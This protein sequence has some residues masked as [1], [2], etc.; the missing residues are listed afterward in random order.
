MAQNESSL[1][2]A[3]LGLLK[4][5]AMSGYDVRK[6]FAA[7][8]L[9]RFSQSPGAIYPALG[10]LERRRWIAGVLETRTALRPRK[11]YRPTAKGLRHLKAWLLA[12]VVRSD[13]VWRIDTLML[14]FSL[15]S[16]T[17]ETGEVIGFLESFARELASYVPSLREYYRE[18]SQ[19]MPLSGRLALK[20]GIDGYQGQLRFVRG[21]IGELE[22]S[23][24]LRPRSRRDSQR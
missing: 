19:D 24:A 8:P 18:Y 7:T 5:Q 11:V 3:L 16:H 17:L 1:E 15:M 10:R 13:V 4:Q 6:V 20:A 12:P 22:R 9:M 2:Y 23:K 21:A 14:K